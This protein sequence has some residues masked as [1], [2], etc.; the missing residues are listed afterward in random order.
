MSIDSATPWW[1][2]KEFQTHRSGHKS[3]EDA[4][5]L[6]KSR[7]VRFRSGR[8]P[9]N[10]LVRKGIEQPYEVVGQPDCSVENDVVEVIKIGRQ[11][12][13]RHMAYE[14]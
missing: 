14:G 7:S 5:F 3:N 10:T 13:I 6:Y 4:S 9:P 12:Q 8:E 2:V 11:S 1:E